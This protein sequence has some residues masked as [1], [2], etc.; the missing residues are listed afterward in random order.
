ML[1]QR[2]SGHY[3]KDC[4]NIRVDGGKV[5][6]VDSRLMV[7]LLI[8]NKHTFSPMLQIQRCFAIVDGVLY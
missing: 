1:E 8:L 5:I 6:D 2:I 4:I 3:F 7:E